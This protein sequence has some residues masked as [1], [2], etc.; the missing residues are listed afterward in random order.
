MPKLLGLPLA[1]GPDGAGD[2]ELSGV[3]EGT[4][5][6]FPPLAGGAS[7]VLGPASG[8]SRKDKR[9]YSQNNGPG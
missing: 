1:D 3:P 7:D 6:L 4:E 8:E 5:L 9:R 2:V